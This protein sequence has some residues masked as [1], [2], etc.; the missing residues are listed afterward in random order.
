MKHMTTRR[1]YGYSELCQ[2]TGLGL[3]T[4]KKLIAD[5]KLASITVGRRRLVPAEALEAFIA[6]RLNAGSA[7]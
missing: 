2:L 6:E 5:G 3:T 4:V 7:S 1:L